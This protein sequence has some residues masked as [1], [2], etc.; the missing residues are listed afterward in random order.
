M[1][2]TGTT[3][4][5]FKDGS[6]S[7]KHKNMAMERQS[8]LICPT[9]FMIQEPHLWHACITWRSGLFVKIWGAGTQPQKCI[10]NVMLGKQQLKYQ[11]DHGWIT[12]F[13]L[14]QLLLHISWIIK[15]AWDGMQTEPPVHRWWLPDMPT[16]VYD[17]QGSP[18]LTTTTW[19]LFPGH[20]QTCLNPFETTHHQLDAVLL[21]LYPWTCNRDSALPFQVCVQTA[22]TPHPHWTWSEQSSTA[23][24]CSKY[25]KSTGA[26]MCLPLKLTCQAP[27]CSVPWWQHA[28]RIS[29]AATQLQIWHTPKSGAAELIEIHDCI[30]SQLKWLTSM[31]RINQWDCKDQ[32][33]ADK[34]SLVYICCKHHV[35]GREQQPTT[36]LPPLKYKSSEIPQIQR[37]FGSEDDKTSLPMSSW[38][39]LPPLQNPCF[40]PPTSH[41]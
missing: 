36:K 7:K 37:Q 27:L 32:M 23:T 15:R 4:F 25:L 9:H 35:D 11:P 2:M 24:Q 33:R 17:K 1:Q 38:S 18:D 31:E 29:M 14:C 21:Y 20:T 10:C 22:E 19:K 26:A 41:V 12:N 30:C 40:V 5:S 28:N 16:S 6:L 34:L 13:T 3:K 8:P 39:S